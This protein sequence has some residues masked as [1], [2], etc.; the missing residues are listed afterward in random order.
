ME[1]HEKVEISKEI[2]ERITHRRE[3]L[4]MS[5]RKLGNL[6]G[7]AGSQIG[8]IEKCQSG[9]NWPT[10]FVIAVH[11]RTTTEWLETGTGS[12]ERSA[13]PCCS[14]PDD[15]CMEVNKLDVARQRKLVSA[16]QQNLIV[17]RAA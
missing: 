14:V 12:E 9:T 2:A 15:L 16:L 7:I 6:V 4:G 3:A 13:C 10:F 1:W 17:R 11:L 5:Q 8:R